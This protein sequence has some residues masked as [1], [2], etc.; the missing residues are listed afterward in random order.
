M[1][2]GSQECIDNTDRLKAMDQTCR[3]SHKK[4]KKKKKKKKRGPSAFILKEGRVCAK[5]PL[6]SSAAPVQQACLKKGEE[7]GKRHCAWLGKKGKK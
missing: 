2:V 6:K 1:K 5:S 7:G 4:K 3:E